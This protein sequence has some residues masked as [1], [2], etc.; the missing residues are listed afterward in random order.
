MPA[1]VLIVDDTKAIR[2]LL[3]IVA[4]QAGLD[5]CGT[6]GDGRDGVELA[7]EY[8]PDAVVLDQQMPVLDGV[9]ALPLIVEAAPRA[10]VVMFS[11]SDEPGLIDAALSRGAAAYFRK[12]VH[13]ADEVIAFLRE[14]VEGSA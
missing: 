11:S 4:E 13:Q 6:A 9:S 2:D 7:R 12:G 10:T 8:Q 3:A 1:R 14:R 5:V